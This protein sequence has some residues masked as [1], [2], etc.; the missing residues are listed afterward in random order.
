M[1][2]CILD[3]IVLNSE[4]L[5]A[6]P[7]W[8]SDF[9]VLCVFGFSLCMCVCVCVRLPCVLGHCLRSCGGLVSEYPGGLRCIG[10][11]VH[12][13]LGNLEAGSPQNQVAPDPGRI[14]KPSVGGEGP[15]PTLCCSPDVNTC[16]RTAPPSSFGLYP[17]PWDFPYLLKYKQLKN[18]FMQS[19]H[20]GAAETNLASNHEVAGSIP[21]LAQ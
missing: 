5:E 21:G 7:G 19:C 3:W 16:F 1:L 15:A 18:S 6:G 20:C 11:P 13:L 10:F 2:V 14:P 9:V 12:I 17:S 4:I 8:E